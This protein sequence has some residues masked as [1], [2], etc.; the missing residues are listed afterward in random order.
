MGK[1]PCASVM[2]N[3]VPSLGVL[4]VFAALSLVLFLAIVRF[5]PNGLK[6]SNWLPQDDALLASIYQIDSCLGH[7][8]VIHE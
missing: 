7:S 6:E 1:T 2:S 8:L 3:M 4:L 5:S